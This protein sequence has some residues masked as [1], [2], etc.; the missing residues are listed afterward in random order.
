MRIY[1]PGET[2]NPTDFPAI[3][4]I[5]DSWFW[6]P[7][8]NILEAV[9][10]HPAL[11]D[12]YRNIQ[13][14]G[15]NGVPINQ[16]V[17]AGRFAAEFQRELVQTVC[18]YY[19]AVMISGGGNDSVDYK[20]ALKADCSG[21]TVAN[22]CIDPDG[23]DGLLR[24]ISG[25]IGLMIHDIAWAFGKQNRMADVFIHGYDYSVPDGR[26]FTLAGRD[27]AGPWLKPALDRANVA[28]DD[29][30]LRAAICRLLI[31]QLNATLARF[32]SPSQGVH[33]IDCRGVLRQDADYKDD[34]DN[35][36]HPTFS[37]FKRV[38]DQR[39]IPILRREGYAT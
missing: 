22:D 17:G 4:A 8:N 20:L 13:L 5:G 11:K 26:G 18:V 35:E 21:L 7:K 1:H 38:V 36:L 31:D 6:Y 23:L 37:G 30:P 2:W 15:Y 16:F 9:L 10:E 12:D 32:D 39:W 28:A 34:W 24:D 25:S 27:V 3:L 19:N 29:L 33:Y 14:L